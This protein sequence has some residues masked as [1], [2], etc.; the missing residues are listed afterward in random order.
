ML[1]GACCTFPSL[2]LLL[3]FLDVVQSLF[4]LK[5]FVV[6]DVLK[7]LWLIAE[8]QTNVII[9]FGSY[10]LN[11]VNK[12]RFIEIWSSSLCYVQNINCWIWIAEISSIET[13]QR[14][15]DKNHPFSS[16][17]TNAVM[18]DWKIWCASDALWPPY[19]ELIMCNCH[20]AHEILRLNKS[21][22]R[23]FIRL[24]LGLRMFEWFIHRYELHSSFWDSTFWLLIAVVDFSHFI[25]KTFIF[26]SSLNNPFICSSISRISFF[27]GIFVSFFFPV[28]FSMIWFCHENVSAVIDTIRT[29]SLNFWMSLNPLYNSYFSI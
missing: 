7:T 3:T 27:N 29:L 20:I 28:L 15:F 23:S 14:T 13:I 8:T 10:Q 4:L 2:H 24:L 5:I 26:V 17:A 1:L 11:S 16:K 25:Y 21:V 22:F 6:P 18:F 19:N 12:Q 9:L